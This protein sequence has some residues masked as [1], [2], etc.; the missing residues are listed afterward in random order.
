M[1]RPRLSETALTLVLIN[2]QNRL[3]AIFAELATSLEAALQELAIP[4]Q[5]SENELDPNG[6]NILLGAT[7]FLPKDFAAYA[8]NKRYMIYQLEQLSLETGV[9]PDY[10]HYLELLRNAVA[11]WDYSLTNV[12]FLQQQGINRVIHF[13]IAYHPTLRCLN[14]DVSKDID[15]IFCGSLRPRRLKIIEALRAQGLRVETPQGIY[16]DARNALIARS[17]IQLNIHQEDDL[18]ILEELRLTFLLANRCFVISEHSDHDPYAGGVVF[19][20]Y[21]EIVA[22]CLKYLNDP[23]ERDLIAQRGQTVIMQQ[24][25]GALLKTVLTQTHQFPAHPE[26]IVKTPILN[27]TYEQSRIELLSII[28]NE[29]S[30]ILDIGCATG[31]LGRLLKSR[32]PCHIT[33]IEIEPDLAQRAA[34]VLDCVYSGD[35]PALITDLPDCHYDVIILADALEYMDDT[36][37]VLSRIHS[38]LAPQGSLIISVPNIRHENI[39]NNLLEGDWRYRSEANSDRSQLRFFTLQSL[40]KNLANHD[41]YIQQVQA[42]IQQR[43]TSNLTLNALFDE[44]Q[45]NPENFPDEMQHAR[46]SVVCRKQPYTEQRKRYDALT[47][48]AWLYQAR[49]IHTIGLSKAAFKVYR[50]IAEFTETTPEIWLACIQTARLAEE[51]SYLSLAEVIAYYLKAYERQPQRAESLVNLARI[52]RRHKQ[53]AL[54]YLYAKQAVKLS[55][56]LQALALNHACYDWQA[57]DE[58]ALACYWTGNYP[59]SEKANRQLL[60][61]PFLPADQRNRI[62]ENLNWALKHQNKA[63]ESVS[64]THDNLPQNTATSAERKAKISLRE[65]HNNSICFSVS[66]ITQQ[67]ID[68]RGY[69]SL[70]ELK[71][72]AGVE[73]SEPVKIPQK[74]LHCVDHQPWSEYLS[75]RTIAFST[76]QS[77]FFEILNDDNWENVF[78]D[79][80]WDIIIFDVYHFRDCVKPWLNRCIQHLAPDGVLFMHDVLPP[81]QSYTR[82]YSDMDYWTG[83]TYKVWNALCRLYPNTV[84]SIN[85]RIGVGIGVIPGSIKSIWQ[86]DYSIDDALSWTDYC[87]NRASITNYRGLLTFPYPEITPGTA[88][89]DSKSSPKATFPSAQTYRFTYII[90][91]RHDPQQLSRLISIIDWLNSFDDIEILIVEQDDASKLTGL[92]LNIRH[93]FLQHAGPFNQ[94]WAFNVGLKN[95]ATPFIVFGNTRLFMA[96]DQ[97]RSALDALQQTDFIKPYGTVITLD[98]T[99]GEQDLA[100]LIKIQPPEISP[101]TRQKLPTCTGIAMF[102]RA[103]ILK[104]GGWSEQFWGW[105]YADHYQSLKVEYFLNW[106]EMPYIGYQLGQSEHLTDNRLSLNNRQLFTQFQRLDK[107][108]VQDAITLEATLIGLH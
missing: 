99:K 90:A 54:A 9:L 7:C 76:E 61:S 22:T 66:Q 103:A 4:Y 104:I 40:I 64:A 15:V 105:G 75:E 74:T 33:G 57:L 98:T 77:Q 55:K 102:T 49:Y 69:T 85:D 41:F 35:P 47:V 62:S 48:R 23:A 6:L 32:Q 38:K 43:E 108:E 81:C 20:P 45:K 53:H 97:F 5:L 101:A 72:I 2:G 79:R 51:H 37:A 36:D 1:T 73:H 12:R 94:S 63:P 107:K 67:W 80:Q 28:P 95:S 50:N 10:L 13:P 106:Q 71:K 11:V 59:A 70:L 82:L 68:V 87:E 93:I 91:Y 52:H 30:N 58:F 8:G 19:C 39:V 60:S 78:G 92:N 56:P 42:Q 26:L 17:K 25:T 3:K 84:Y 88:L 34:T 44:L 46:Y 21:A 14:Q 89:T 24:Q 16:G 86:S 96:S 65:S 100:A 18:P 29:A 27:T 31:R 83:E